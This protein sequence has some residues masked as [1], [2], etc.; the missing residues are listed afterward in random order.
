MSPHALFLFPLL[1]CGTFNVYTVFF[2]ILDSL[3]AL[4]TDTDS[5]IKS[6]TSMT[7][8]TLC[9]FQCSHKVKALLMV[10]EQ[11]KQAVR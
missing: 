2:R 9:A 7:C 8:M 3:A 6:S 10:V 5:L 4:H 1:I 11:Q